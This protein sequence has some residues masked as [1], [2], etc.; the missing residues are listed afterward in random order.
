MRVVFTVA[1]VGTA[2]AIIV[3]A[4]GPI[5]GCDSSTCNG[6]CL[7]NGTC[8]A[9]TTDANC[10]TG[11]KLCVTCPST[12]IC[13]V[14]TG[15]CAVCGAGSCAGCCWDNACRPGTENTY[16]GTGGQNCFNCAGARCSSGTCVCPAGECIGNDSNCYKCTPPA[17]CTR[18]PAVGQVCGAPNLG[19]YCCN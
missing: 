16:C 19:V 7:T 17:T 8:L 4:C 11:G 18:S 6:C 9:G 13:S 5:R 2:A 12:Q 14:T 10:G 1:A 3:P 15:T